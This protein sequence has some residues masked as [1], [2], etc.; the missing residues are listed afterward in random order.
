MPAFVNASNVR[1]YAGIDGITAPWSEA[2]LGSNIRAASAFLEKRTGRQFE[3]Q[4]NTTKKFTTNGQAYINVPDLRSVSSLTL[5]TAAQT[6]DTDYYLIPDHQ[7][8]GVYIGVQFRGFG[9]GT[10]YRTRADWFDRNLDR[11]PWLVGSEPNDLSITGDWGHSPIPEEV[12]HATKV[13]AAW[14]TRR[15]DA[16]L[17][18]VSVTAGGTEVDLGAIPAEV[19]L[20]IEEWKLSAQVVGVG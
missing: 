18:G 9:R 17:G 10:D 12:M 1:A 14:F 6:A 5:S 8:T 20:F 3:L 7:Q 16:L 13:L 11:H 2:N 19:R 4:L 15:P